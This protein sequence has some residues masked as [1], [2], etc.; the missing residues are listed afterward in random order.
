M[1]NG[2]YEKTLWWGDSKVALMNPAPCIITLCII[3]DPPVQV[4]LLTSLQP[5]QYGEDE[6][7]LL[8]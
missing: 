2:L 3:P 1:R 5:E 8:M 6:E 7:T 4:E